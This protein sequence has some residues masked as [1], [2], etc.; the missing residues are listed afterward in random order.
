MALG[1]GAPKL[2]KGTTQ[3]T[4]DSGDNAANIPGGVD[5]KLLLIRLSPEFRYERWGSD[6]HSV[7]RNVSLPPSNL[8]QVEFL[9]G[10]S[11]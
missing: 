2:D 10:L 9:V 11:F 1:H 6:S 7:L 5:F 4:V 3:F 8:N